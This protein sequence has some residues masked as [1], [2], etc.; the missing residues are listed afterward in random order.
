[1]CGVMQESNLTGPSIEAPLTVQK[2]RI[3]VM[4]PSLFI[5]WVMGSQYADDSQYSFL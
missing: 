2:T 3:M 4:S 5:C 1:M